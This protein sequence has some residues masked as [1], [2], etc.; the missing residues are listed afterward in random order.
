[1]NN[2]S[3]STINK[4]S[5]LKSTDRQQLQTLERFI[6]EIKMSKLFVFPRTQTKEGKVFLS[7]GK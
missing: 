6:W 1:M 2:V 3:I 7:L 5:L 4:N